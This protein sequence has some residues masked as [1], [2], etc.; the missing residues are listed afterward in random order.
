MVWDSLGRFR[1]YYG[2]VLVACSTNRLDSDLFRA[3]V[4]SNNANYRRH[5]AYESAESAKPAQSAI[6]VT[7]MRRTFTWAIS[8]SE[9]RAIG[10]ICV[11]QPFPC[12]TS[13]L[14]IGF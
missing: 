3:M 4:M 14:R 7:K 8:R 13:R 10:L 11:G 9:Q 12:E 6:F 1:P 2:R 5:S